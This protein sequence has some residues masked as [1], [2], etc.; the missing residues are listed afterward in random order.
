M[1]AFK[2][3]TAALLASLM[4]AGTAAT[5]PVTVSAAESAV[6]G[7]TPLTEHTG[8]YDY[9]FS[10]RTQVTHGYDF[11]LDRISHYATD[12]ALAMSNRADAEIVDGALTVKEGKDFIFGSAVGLGDD[13]G[14]E[15]G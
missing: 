8:G 14:L 9:S 1:K 15:E 10:K 3:I 13:Y 2:R 4:L 6:Y 5:L 12:P 7:G 11:S